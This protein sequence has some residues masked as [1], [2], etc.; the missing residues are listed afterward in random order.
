[1]S[2]LDPPSTIRIAQL[3]R[4]MRA[5]L[6]ATTAIGL[7]IALSAIGA[8]SLPSD[9][10]AQLEG[11]RSTSS[12]PAS[13]GSISSDSKRSTRGEFSNKTTMTE[14]RSSTRSSGRTIEDSEAAKE[15]K[16]HKEKMAEKEREMRRRGIDPDAAE[17]EK[18]EDDPDG[19][20]ARASMRTGPACMYGPDGRVIYKPRGAV[21]RRAPR[22]QRPSQQARPRMDPLAAPPAHPAANRRA[23]PKARPK[24]TKGTCMYGANGELIYSSPGAVCR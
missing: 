8:L 19:D 22:A 6:A 18:W 1:M 7:A 20:P 9:A 15:W 11:T 17:R 3:P 2:R 24:K 14:S 13:S 5:L 23:K 12:G 16:S 10:S 4:P 21:C